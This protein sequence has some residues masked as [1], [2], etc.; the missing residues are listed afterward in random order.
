MLYD[1][2]TPLYH[3][4]NRIK[5]F[6]TGA[7]TRNATPFMHRYLYKDHTPLCILE[8]FTA[9]VLYTNRN[10]AN[11]AMVMRA[12]HRNVGNLVRA[13]SG[14]A[15]ATVPEKLA[16]T[17]ALFLY[18]VIRLFDGDVTLR[19]QG[20]ADI[21]LLQTWLGELC[22]VRE[23]LGDLAELEDSLVR[24]QPPKE[25]EV[26]NISVPKLVMLLLTRFGVTR[27]GY[28]RNLYEGL[29]SWP[30]LSSRSIR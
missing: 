11:M 20:E 9:N 17:Q 18:Q 7:A 25:W 23:N 21:P 15:A 26:S 8:C 14:R 19:A 5:G 3:V 1:P 2:K 24:A 28:S 13:E 12:L 4:V 30:T 22:K 16:R 10:P 6:T 27:D 29:S